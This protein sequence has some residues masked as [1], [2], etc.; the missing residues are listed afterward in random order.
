MLVRST[1]LG[2]LL[3]GVLA[4]PSAV[5][6]QASPSL[7]QMAG[8]MIIVG[9]K[10][11]GVDSKSVQGLAKEMST[12]DLGGV[13]YL[14]PNVASAAA[15]KQMNQLFAAADPALPPP[16]IAVDQE[17]GFVQR[18]TPSVG[19]PD[20][21]S[22]ENVAK[23]EDQDQA[24]ATYEKMAAGLADLGFNLNFGP[25][26]DLNLNPKNPIIGK[27]GRSY[28]TDAL[29]VGR[30]A[31]SF[32]EAHHDHG[33]LTALKHFPGHGSSTG[34]THLGF[35]DVTKTWQESELTS[36]SYIM[37][38]ATVD[39]VMV[40]HLYNANFPDGNEK[41]PAS[42]SPHWVTQILRGQLK[43]DGVVVSDDLEMGAI[44]KMF[45]L[46]DTVVKA[47]TAGV[48]ILL[49]SNSGD[50]SP[51]LVDKVRGIIVDEAQKDPAFKANVEASYKRIIALKDRIGH[52]S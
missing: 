47:V 27:F 31:F 19:V 36:F 16:F 1:L 4:A 6:A 7:E 38:H 48:D 46:H 39:M 52:T 37:A 40:G 45:D 13:M 44:V 15:V 11:D 29:T 3:L 17:G 5:R 28:G 41:L 25:V 34:D 8:Q 30:Y 10:G 49:F 20:T 18:L 24:R 22:A 50:Y 2:A 12:G 9:F 42:L 26:A 32:I 35:V 23:T 21:P 14:K 43:Y 51:D 33:V